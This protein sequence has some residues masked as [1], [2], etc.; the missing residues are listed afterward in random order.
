MHVSI[1]WDSYKVAVQV[2]LAQY[3]GGMVKTMKGASK[4]LEAK[5]RSMKH[6]NRFPSAPQA[7][8]KEWDMLQSFDH[9][10]LLYTLVRSGNAETW[11]SAQHA[12]YRDVESMRELLSSLGT[13]KRKVNPTSDATVLLMPSQAFMRRLHEEGADRSDR[14]MRDA[15]RSTADDYISYYM[16]QD[17]NKRDGSGEYDLN[18]A[19]VLYESFYVLEAQSP[20]WSKV[21]LF[22]CNCLECFKCASCCHSLLAGMMCDSSIRVPAL[23]L[24]VTVQSRRKRGRPSLKASEVSDAGEA[25]AR[26]RIELQEQYELRTICTS[27]STWCVVA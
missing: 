9:R 6:P 22:K 13:A 26:A 23:S 18:S 10:T 12:V 17:F 11:R 7:T 3:L 15:V 20:R 25:R 16:R 1:V 5:F 27:Q 2:G 8:T 24:G 4:E 19:L 21:H 14:D